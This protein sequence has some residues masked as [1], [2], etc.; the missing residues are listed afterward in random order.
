MAAGVMEGAEA[1]LAC[2]DDDIATV[3]DVIADPVPDARNVLDA[4]RNLPTLLPDVRN[5]AVDECLIDI[6]I[7]RHEAGSGMDVARLAQN[8][9]QRLFVG[10]DNFHGS[11]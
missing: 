4:A 11:P 3:Y 7:E 6:A 2:A 9:G 8:C 5:L 1:T 10:R